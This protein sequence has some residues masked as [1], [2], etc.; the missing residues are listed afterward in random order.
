MSKFVC[1]YE[2]NVTLE[3]GFRFYVVLCLYCSV[4]TVAYFACVHVHVETC[5]TPTLCL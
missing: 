4:F 3:D 5:T 1:Q 2:Y